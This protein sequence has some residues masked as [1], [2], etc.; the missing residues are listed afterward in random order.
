MVLNS[1]STE[2]ILKS[3]PLTDIL[4]DH[5][6]FWIQKFFFK[7]IQKNAESLSTRELCVTEK[8]ADF[9][10]DSKNNPG[11][12][13]SS[14]MAVFLLS[15]QAGIPTQHRGSYDLWMGPGQTLIQVV[16]EEPME[17]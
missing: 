16:I 7:W 2:N 8:P 13:G 14:T 11:V 15:S 9:G 10:K 6:K 3:T 1:L 5:V 17:K 4:S 12:M